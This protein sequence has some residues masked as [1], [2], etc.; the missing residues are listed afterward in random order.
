VTSLLIKNEFGN[1]TL[2][3]LFHVK[4]MHCGNCAMILEGLEDEL[5]GISKISASYHKQQLDVEF[6]ESQLSAD[7]IIQAARQKGY[8]LVLS[9]QN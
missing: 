7:E 9:T 3:I 2:K 8:D 4:N 6:D 1:K 5:P